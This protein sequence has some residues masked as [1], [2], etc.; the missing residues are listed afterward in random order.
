M[1][2]YV[3]ITMGPRNLSQERVEIAVVRKNAPLFATA[4]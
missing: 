1:R 3:V 4:N 2:E